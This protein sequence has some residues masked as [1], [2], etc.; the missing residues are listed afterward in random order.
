M[1]YASFGLSLMAWVPLG[2]S[3]RAAIKFDRARDRFGETPAPD[4]AEQLALYETAVRQREIMAGTLVATFALI[5]PSMILMVLALRRH[6]REPQ[7][8]RIV[9]TARPDR[10][11]MGF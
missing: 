2:F 1:L 6:R 7:R 11:V 3:I 5:V 8:K 9:M 10:G 4:P